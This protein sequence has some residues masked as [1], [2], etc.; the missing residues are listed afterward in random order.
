MVK[1]SLSGALGGIGLLQRAIK[2]VDMYCMSEFD[3]CTV[4]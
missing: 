3:G 2:Y 4:T 1:Y